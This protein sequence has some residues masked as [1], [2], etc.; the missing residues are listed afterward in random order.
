MEPSKTYVILFDEKRSR[1]FNLM[2]NALNENE[3]FHRSLA[4]YGLTDTY[5]KLEDES[6][7]KV[8]KLDMCP[9]PDCEYDK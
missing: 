9:D 7:E 2:L 4:H 1:V 5:Q 8:H 3:R 6:G